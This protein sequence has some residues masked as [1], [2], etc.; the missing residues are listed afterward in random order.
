MAEINNVIVQKQRIHY[1]DLT[2]GIAIILIIFAHCLEYYGRQLGIDLFVLPFIYSFHVP[3][4]FIASGFL[5]SLGKEKNFLDFLIKRIRTI[6]FPYALFSFLNIVSDM[7][8]LY[9]FHTENDINIKRDIV[10]SIVQNHYNALWFL[11]VLFVVQVLAFF[12]V[13]MTTKMIIASL[14]LFAIL[15]VVYQLLIHAK[16]PWCVD[17][18]PYVMPFFIGG[19]LLKKHDLCQSVL[20]MKYLP[21]YSILG[22]ASVCL[23]LKFGH[24]NCVN[25]FGTEYGNL[26]FFYLA[27]FNNCFAVMTLAK[28]IDSLSAVNYLGKY[29][30]VYYGIHM[31]LLHLIIHFAEDYYSQTTVNYFVYCTV[32]TVLIVLVLTPVNVILNKTPLRFLIGKFQMSGK[33]KNE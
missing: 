32:T 16:L 25:I 4:F 11:C 22:I 27:A 20:R 8:K 1:I 19:Y 2:K 6:L 30:L 9:L 21:L 23:N 28:R 24:L 17:T 33:E 10:D 7:M 5:F 15:A 3:L 31:L 12:I 29:S 13:K 26:L 14:V 18:V